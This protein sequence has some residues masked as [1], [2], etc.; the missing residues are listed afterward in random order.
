[1]I[2]Y[3]KAEALLSMGRPQD[4]AALID[5]I[6]ARESPGPE[7]YRL[8]GRVLRAA[9][10]LYDAEA[11]FREAL[12]LSPDDPALLADLATVL[13]GQRR[14][15]EAL[16]YA[17]EAVALRPDCAAWHCLIAVIAEGLDLEEEALRALESAQ[18]LSPADP[19]PPAL[20]GFLLLRLGRPRAAEPAF[21][22]ALARDPRRADPLLGLARC[23]AAAEDWPAAR[24]LWR[25]ALALDPTLRDRALE[26]NSWL[27][28]PWMRP[29]LLAARAPI[30]LSAGMLGAG[31]LI[32][33]LLR[34]PAALALPA[35]AA[36]PPLLRAWINRSPLDG[37]LL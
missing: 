21:R 20:R 11:A 5:R 10:R 34:H 26:Q 27:G 22:D 36:L 33:A 23:A 8:R 4:A 31:M 24:R 29:V 30:S 16:A 25:D 18:S 35:L 14:L 3:R 2:E 13:L 12:A 32:L 9:S 37:S 19:E 6:P 15:R 1:M 17:R 7:F 28:E